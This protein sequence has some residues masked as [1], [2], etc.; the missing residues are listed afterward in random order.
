MWE[1]VPKNE[2]K[3]KRMGTRGAPRDKRQGSGKWKMGEKKQLQET[4][5]T[6]Q[7][8]GTRNNRQVNS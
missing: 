3:D 7:G 8:K 2:E 1:K 6:S 5:E 4:M